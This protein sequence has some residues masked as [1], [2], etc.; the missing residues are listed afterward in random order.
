MYLPK[1]EYHS[2]MSVKEVAR[3]LKELDARAEMMAG[4]TDL[5]P[6][7]KYGL[8]RPEHLIS[9][10]EIPAEPP[11]Q[12]EDGALCLDTHITLSEIVL[13]PGESL[14]LLQSEPSF[15][16]CGPLFQTRRRDVLFCNK[17]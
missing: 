14:P 2:P 8:V 1:F 3:L 6:R 15:P 11:V 13:S 9:L 7:M 12:L 17:K 10:K 16:V 4:G 5:L